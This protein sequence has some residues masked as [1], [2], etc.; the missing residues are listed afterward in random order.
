MTKRLEDMTFQEFWEEEKKHSNIEALEKDK[1][2]LLETLRDKG[3]SDQQI[4][5]MKMKKAWKICGPALLEMVGQRIK[6]LG[7]SFS[8]LPEKTIEISDSLATLF[9]T[10]EGRKKLQTDK[11]L[12]RDLFELA[13]AFE[14]LENMLY[15][16]EER[17]RQI[18]ELFKNEREEKKE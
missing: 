14:D 2:M 9:E 4:N 17:I 16:G 8:K 13:G 1:R 7:K 6:A 3:F 12:R 11:G 10:E 18:Y 15:L 5:E